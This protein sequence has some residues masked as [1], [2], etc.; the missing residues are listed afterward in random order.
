ML[1][2]G[3]IPFI[4]S[5]L[6]YHCVITILVMG[7][8]PVRITYIS[9]ILMYFRFIFGISS[10]YRLIKMIHLVWFH[11]S[12]C[13]ETFSVIVTRVLPLMIILFY[14]YILHV[15]NSLGIV[16]IVWVCH[17]IFKTHIVCDTIFFYYGIVVSTY[18]TQSI[19]LLYIWL[20]LRLVSLILN[21]N[22]V[23]VRFIFHLIF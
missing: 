17:L 21:E 15:L 4:I 8:F 10:N 6:T 1:K 19:I 2:L 11:D 22:F 5:V 13:I 9:L 16:F 14:R 18:L 7:Y 3:I 23:W 12:C 20:H